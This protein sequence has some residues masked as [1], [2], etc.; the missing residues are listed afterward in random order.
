MAIPE[1]MGAAVA[2]GE[3]LDEVPDEAPDELLEGVVDFELATPPK[4]GLN[5]LRTPAAGDAICRFGSDV[6]LD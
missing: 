1:V 3:A 5:C 2:E 4:L 6:R